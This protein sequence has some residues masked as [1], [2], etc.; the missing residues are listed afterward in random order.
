[1][2]ESGD[3][4]A[5]WAGARGYAI[6][7]RR[8]AADAT[9]DIVSALLELCTDQVD[10][11]LTTG[12]TG[13][14]TR[15]VTPEATLAVIERNVPGIAERIRY[16]GFAK[17]PYATLSRG[18]AGVRGRTLILNLPGSTTGVNDGLAVLDTL[19]GHIVQLLR[20]VDTDRHG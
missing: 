6:T 4:I 19:I 18:V 11:V 14:T 10:I 17:T 13:L 16:E 15:D 1:M 5:A 8:V 2:D 7:D 12:G 9:S 3:A 20:G